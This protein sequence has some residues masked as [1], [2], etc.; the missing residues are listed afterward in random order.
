MYGPQVKIHRHMD[1]KGSM[2]FETVQ[3]C[4]AISEHC[5]EQRAI[6][7]VG[8]G[9]LKHAAKIPEVIVQAYCNLKGIT[10]REFIINKVHVRALLNDPAY[11]DFRIW[12][13]KV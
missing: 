3:D 1:G 13:G 8:S 5:K 12:E 6:G 10:F 7:N 4:T 2:T 9:D 11:A